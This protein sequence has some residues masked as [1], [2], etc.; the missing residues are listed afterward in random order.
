MC[1]LDGNVELAVQRYI[2]GLQYLSKV[3]DL[4]P[5]DKEETEALRLSLHLNLAQA[6]LRLSGS[7]PKAPQFEAFAKKALASCDSA[8]EL[9]FVFPR[10]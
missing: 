1:G 2:K 5:Q 7:D 6:Y 9:E 4:S 3:F 8:L 10:V